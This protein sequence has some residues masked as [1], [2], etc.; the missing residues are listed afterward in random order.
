MFIKYLSHMGFIV[1]MF[2]ECGAVCV[3]GN[4]HHWQ[5]PHCHHT[6][7]VYV[8][9]YWSAA[10]QGFIFKISM[11]IAQEIAADGV[12]YFYFFLFHVTGQIL[13]LHR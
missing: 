11:P 10:F 4:P 2:T 5:H 8:C 13:Q 3:R 1:C 12:F 9:V 7:S 6:P